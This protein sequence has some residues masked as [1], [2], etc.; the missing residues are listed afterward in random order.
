MSDAP[1]RFR[2]DPRRSRALRDALS[3]RRAPVDYDAVR[4]EARL[5]AAIAGLAV[6]KPAPPTNGAASTSAAVNAGAATF[7]G[8]AIAVVAI[9]AAVALPQRAPRVARAPTPA[10]ILAIA[11]ARPTA[12]PEATPTAEPDAALVT[13]I[14]AELRRRRLLRAPAPPIAPTPL[15][16]DSADALTEELRAMNEL[17]RETDPAR[18]LALV[19]TQRARFPQGRFAEEREAFAVLALRLRIGRGAAAREQGGAFL[20]AVRG[21]AFA[22]EIREALGSLGSAFTRR[23]RERRHDPLKRRARAPHE[24]SFLASRRGH[25]VRRCRALLSLRSAFAR[26]TE[27]AMR[28][29]LGSPHRRARRF[30]SR[31]RGLRLRAT[32]RRRRR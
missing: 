26:R 3:S 31:G 15:P 11:T 17:R 13:P 30:L 1:I 19:E 5:A 24:G 12:T 7:V 2:D 23:F 4:G 14:E 20:A 22:A 21:S 9:L 25:R 16:I 6:A 29:S 28:V 10:P 32:R 18:A 27:P 8:S